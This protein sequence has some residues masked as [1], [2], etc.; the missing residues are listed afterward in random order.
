M[1]LVRL[2]WY[3]I[4]AALP[5]VCLAE[6][7]P[8]TVRGLPLDVIEAQPLRATIAYDVPAGLGAVRLHVEMKSP[9]H[10][11]VL[12]GQ[13][14]T[15]QGKGEVVTELAAPARHEEPTVYLAIWYGEVWT[16]AIGPIMTT[17][18]VAVLSTADAAAARAQ[19]KA[20][21]AWRHEHAAALPAGGVAAVLTDDLPGLDVGYARRVQAALE[22][23]GLRTVALTAEQVAN[24]GL[25]TTDHFHTLVLPNCAVYPASGARAFARFIAQGGDVIALGAPAFRQPLRRLGDR[26]VTDEQLRDL[27]SKQPIER[28]L[29]DFERGQVADWGH[30]SGGGSPAQY[31]VT[32]GGANGTGRALH[33][34]VP[35]FT[36]WN[37]LVAPLLPEPPGS[38][39]LLTVLWAKGDAATTALALE[40]VE[41]DGSRWIATVPLTAQWQ[42]YALAAEDF[43]YWQDSASKGRGGAGD[44]LHVGN[45]QK[46]TVGLAM[47]HTPMGSGRKEFWVDEIGVSRDPAPA[48]ELPGQ[49]DLAPVELLYPEYKFHRVSNAATL[50]VSDKQV[51]LSTDSLPVPAGLMSVQPRPQGTGFN[52]ERKW[53]FIPLLEARDKSG[54]VCGTPACLLIN[55]TGRLQRSCIATFALPPSACDNAPVLGM[56][57][58]LTKRLRQGRFLCEGGAEF[59]TVWDGQDVT[60]GA[61]TIALTDA[62]APELKVVLTVTDGKREV[63]R[64]EQ[65]VR[66]GEARCQW[67]PGHFAAD[68]YQ[69]SCSLRDADGALLDWLSHPLLVW[70]PSPRPAFMT[71]EDGQFVREGKPWRAHGVNYMPSSGI[72]IEDGPYF[73]NWLGKQSY[74]PVVIERDLSR[75]AAAGFNMVSIFCYYEALGSRNLLDCLE[76]CRRHGLM[77]NLS[78]R[79]GTPMDFRWDEMRALVEGFRLAEN[80]TVF[81]YDLAWEPSFGDY[82]SRQRWDV[83]WEQWVRQRYGSVANAETDWG[84][85]IPRAE[86]KVTGPS[87]EQLSTEGR[88]RIMVCAYRRFLNDLLDR[89]H[90]RANG[91]VKS[92][93][94]HHFT[95]FRMSI[96]GDPTVSPARIAYDFRG[97]AR[98]VDIMEPEG[99]GRIGDWERVRPGRFTAD[100]SRATA[101]GRPVMW[102][103]FG[104]APYQR[105]AWDISPQWQSDVAAFYDRFYRMA[106]ESGVNGTVA[107][108]YPGG[109]RYGENSDYGIINPDGSWR[110]VTEMI[111][112]WAPR[113][114]A[115]RSHAVD[116]WLTIDPDASVKGIVGAYEA[117]K[118]R[119]FALIEAGQNPGL[120][121]DGF[122]L[123]SAS[124]P[125]RAVGNVPYRPGQNPHK[126]LNATLDR[127]EYRNAQGEWHGVADD[128]T[129][130]AAAE[131]LALRV[132]VGN[133]GEARWLAR[134]GAG[135]VSLQV[136]GAAAASGVLSAD[137]ASMATVTVPVTM[138]APLAPGAE[139]KLQMRA[140]PDVVFGDV[141]RLMVK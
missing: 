50:Q 32:P 69:V 30:T 48:T 125:R 15:V 58:E 55:R 27:R 2:L 36:S 53:R 128:G 5:A 54:E 39:P 22:Q 134:S 121:T 24:P 109:F 57:A 72:G 70:R 106:D 40:W 105:D 98:T 90:A 41:R 86:G 104:W 135:Q 99:Y 68:T 87:D 91:L 25:L 34:V 103:E 64:S 85:P 43:R 1:W 42:R 132:T 78:L 11:I 81:A 13:Q 59:Y 21:L 102:A 75:V 89:K 63:F 46:L 65:P 61:H 95:S 20:A 73:E 31:D 114:T 84:V 120:R 140:A 94:P 122:G 83:E 115:P 33:C 136:T 79:P 10:N 12:R 28:L 44:R 141:V 137:V 67:R 88:H 74:D 107:W 92:I 66:D 37:T 45:A 8:T 123:D 119:Y 52:K 138:P 108:W 111:H 26:W 76:R 118:E 101:P 4:L 62:P 127:V 23:A 35:G 116:T 100:Y 93:D 29:F 49:M 112:R 3:S 77:V 129:L 126:Y 18:T 139:L 124:A 110:P 38:D 56:V 82:R 51:L 19:Q 96:A 117:V 14:F 47:T 113:M 71:V 97:L 60:L 6:T 7:I 17:D 130:P 131:P 133:S 80:D 16:A 9:R